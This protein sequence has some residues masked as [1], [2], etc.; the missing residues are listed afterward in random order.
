MSTSSDLLVRCLQHAGIEYAFGVPGSHLLPLYD[1][2]CRAGTP[3]V[4]LTCHEQGAA[5]MADGYARVRRRIGLCLGTVGPGAANLISA[6]AAAFMDSIPLLVIT[7]Q[8]RTDH[9]GRAAHQEATGRAHSIRQGDLLRAVTKQCF[10]VKDG[11][12]LAGVAHEA[13][14]LAQS[15]RP[16]PVALEICSD[17]LNQELGELPA[18]PYSWQIDEG[19]ECPDGIVQE[20]VRWLALAER[21]VFLAGGGAVRSGCAGPLRRLAERLNVPVATS[22]LAKGILPEDHPLSLGGIG[23]YGLRLANSYV[24]RADVMIALGEDFREYTTRGWDRKFQP[25]RA[26]IQVDSDP[27]EIGKNYS[28]TIGVVASPRVFLESLERQV[29]ECNLPQRSIEQML[30]LKRTT[31]YFAERE[32]YDDSVPI[33]PQ[34][35]MAVLRSKLPRDT[36]VFKD[37]GKTG[38]WAERYFSTVAPDTF[39][40]AYGFSPMG[41]AVAASIG[42]KLAAPER[43]V[44]C[45]TGD[46]AFLMN[47][48]EIATAAQYRA[49]VVWVILQ[50]RRLG[51]LHDA[52]SALFGD[53]HVATSLPGVDY[54]T[55]AQALGARGFRVQTAGELENAVELALRD[56]SP[57]VIEVGIDPDEKLPIVRKISL[58]D[59]FQPVT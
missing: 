29:A 36:I 12:Y 52:Q 10:Q 31:R 15:G 33:K 42:G 22:L 44:V 7:A 27:D 53:R 17:A 18:E 34:R 6:V 14:I 39:F 41:Y 40:T 1:A 32:M 25:S 16:G 46:G 20:V 5:F 50:D 57:T 56:S 9:Y 43:P 3:Q 8:V 48:M 11:H 24:T 59:G 2:L 51:S 35:V 45:L 21:P 4:V 13:L 23:Y 58:L 26:L 55:L 54:V 19:E 30:E 38:N 37:M 47:G 49:G 28:P